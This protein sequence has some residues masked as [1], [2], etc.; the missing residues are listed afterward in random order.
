MSKRNLW[1]LLVLAFFCGGAEKETPPKK[2]KS[3]AGKYT[4]L[5]P[6]KPKEEIQKTAT[7][8]GQ[9]Q[10][11]MNI[12]EVSNDLAYMVAYNDYPLMAKNVD[13]QKNLQAAR[14]G[15]KGAN[16]KI[17][18]DTEITF[19]KNKI[20]GREVLIAKGPVQIRTKLLLAGKRLYQVMV[21]ATKLEAVNSKDADK[22]FESF[23]IAE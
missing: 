10:L 9:I 14:D 4:V 12:Y 7:A 5:F 21:I 17:L 6:G 23:E 22:F 18:K 15:N 19:G 8:Q 3:E 20:P 2:F 13:P 16:G 11:V 1:I